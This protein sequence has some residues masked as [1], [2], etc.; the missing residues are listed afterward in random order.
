MYAGLFQP[1]QKFCLGLKLSR[2][3]IRILMSVHIRLD[4][5]KSNVFGYSI[6]FIVFSRNFCDFGR[7]FRLT[8]GALLPR[9]LP[10]AR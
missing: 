4:P 8:S 3:I 5:Q 6:N 7:V 1:G 9:L 2:V 10:F